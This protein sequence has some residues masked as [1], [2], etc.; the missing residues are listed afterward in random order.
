MVSL[1]RGY[2]PRNFALVAFGGAGPLHCCLLADELGIIKVIIPTNPGLFSSFG[3][4]V[5]DFRRDYLISAIG[6]T[7]DYKEDFFEKNFKEME[8]NSN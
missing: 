7:D 3:L 6:L 4:I 2:D 5:S 1:E 8:V